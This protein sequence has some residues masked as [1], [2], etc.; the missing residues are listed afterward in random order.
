MARTRN[1]ESAGWCWSSVFFLSVMYLMLFFFFSTVGRTSGQLEYGFYDAT[2]PNVEETARQVLQLYFTSDLTS[3]ASILRLS[4]HYCQVQG[5]D[6][7]VML[8]SA[9]VITTELTELDASSSFSIRRLEI[10][11]RVKATLEEA[12]SNTVSC[13]DIIAMAGP[14]A[15]AYAGGPRITIHLGRRDST[16]ATTSEASASLP[17]PNI[18]MDQFMNLFATHGMNISESVAIMGG[19]TLGVGHCR[20]F[21][22]RPQ[23]SDPSPG[24]VFGAE[25]EAACAA[26]ELTDLLALPNDLTNFV[27]D[28]QYYID[29]RNGHGLFTIDA[30]LALNSTTAD[31]QQTFA[32]DQQAFFDTFVTKKTGR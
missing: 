6:A 9:N 8:D 3:S 24:L 23:E 22:S 14:E 2:C 32:N 29:A 11:D 18:S 16:F 7:S 21:E 20:S 12:C 17:R 13:A 27:F 5:C 25:L 28:N 1:L 30:E 31:I 10:I 19:H 4:F 15:V 26:T